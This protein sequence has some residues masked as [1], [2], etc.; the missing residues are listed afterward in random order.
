[1]DRCWSSHYF[2][3]SKIKGDAFI[4]PSEGGFLASWDDARGGTLEL[5]PLRAEDH[6]FRRSGPRL[7][8]GGVRIAPSDNHRHTAMI[9]DGAGGITRMG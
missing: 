2:G 3:G 1:M 8:P 6:D 4:I 9:S 7:A 5:A